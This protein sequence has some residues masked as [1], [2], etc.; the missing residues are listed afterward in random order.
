MRSRADALMVGSLPTTMAAPC[1]PARHTSVVHRVHRHAMPYESGL[2]FIS[3]P[4][5]APWGV[6]TWRRAAYGVGVGSR[7]SAGHVL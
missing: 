6:R 7:P 4:S 2:F 1:P 3:A 5:P